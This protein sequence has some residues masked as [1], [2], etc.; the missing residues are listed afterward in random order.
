MDDPRSTG[1]PR[2]R[3]RLAGSGAVLVSV[4]AAVALVEAVLRVGNLYRPPDEPVTTARPDLYRADT[5]VGYTLWPSRQTVYRYPEKDGEWIPL[6][7]NSDGFRTPREFDERD[8]RR[9]VLVVGDSFVFGQGVRA[10]DR[11]TERIEELEPAFHVINMGM[12]GWGLDLM[13]RAIERFAAKAAPDVVVLAVYTDDFR[14]LHPYYAGVGFPYPKFVLDGPALATEPFPYPSFWERLRLVQWAYQTAWQRTEDWYALNE[15][16]LDR[17]L[18]LASATGFRPAVAFFP[19]TGDTDRDR[20]R[21]RFLG[22]WA[23][24]HGVPYVDLT[25]PVHATGVEKAYIRDNWHWNA[26]GHRVAAGELAGFLR[27]E[28]GG[29]AAARGRTASARP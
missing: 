26:L 3:A 6:V 18:R 14:R 15:A 2:L 1:A 23:S 12:T 20:E 13:V 17:Y 4:L 10:E 5:A 27:R 25:G 19:G 8:G 16:L 7:S 22:R 21:R 9:R 28:F 11:L 29:E 24:A